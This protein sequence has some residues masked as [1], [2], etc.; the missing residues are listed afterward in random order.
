MSSGNYPGQNDSV[1]G[2][3]TPGQGVG[4]NQ[5]N[6]ARVLGLCFPPSNGKGIVNSKEEKKEGQVSRDSNSSGGS[7]Q[8]NTQLW[9]NITSQP[10]CKQF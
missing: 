8:H 1:Q 7:H 4:F 3:K 6:I 9:Y 10:T 2:P 5:D